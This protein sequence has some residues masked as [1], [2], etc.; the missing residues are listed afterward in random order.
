MAEAKDATSIVI[1]ESF[2]RDEQMW[3]EFAAAR[4]GPDAT[5]ISVS[6]YSSHRRVYVA[7]D[8]VWKIRRI[9]DEDYDRTQSLAGEY[10]ILQTLEGVAGVGRGASYSSDESWET[11]S[12]DLSPGVTLEA[13]L[14]DDPKAVTG[15]LL[16]RLRRVLRG[17]HARGIAHR[18][19]RPDNILIGPGGEITL[20]DFDQAVRVS[21]FRAF[22]LDGYGI[23]SGGAWHTLYALA[24]RHCRWYAAVTWP[25]RAVARLI[26]R[27]KR[28]KSDPEAVSPGMRIPDAPDGPLSLL[29]QAWRIAQRSEA[30]APG[31]TVAYYSLDV[32]G[33]HFPGERPWALRWHHVAENVDFAGKRVLELG[34]NLGLFSAF[35]RRAGAAACTGVDADPDILGGARRVAEALAADV[36]FRQ[37]DF[38]SP[39]DWESEL[40]G[41]DIVLAL[42][43][44]NWVD[45]KDRFRRFLARHDEVLFEGHEPADVDRVMLGEIGFE[46]VTR[47]AT[48]ER[49]RP[50][51][52]ARRT[53]AA[54]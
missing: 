7:G 28:A 23:G 5:L 32:C 19:L 30:N 6:R 29:A 45:D 49:H 2:Q 4:L 22:W 8:R 21:R 14:A 39:E 51:Y 48:S 42:S 25:A 13:A 54:S 40:A 1:Y 41:H 3:D 34:C 46:E 26:R 27:T 16:R 12:Y 38:D 52:H 44:I 31:K 24:R 18:D 43:V 50:V 53:Q 11:L 10:E 35:A 33:E 36:T 9:A 20:L 15:G 17:I 47:V 37:I